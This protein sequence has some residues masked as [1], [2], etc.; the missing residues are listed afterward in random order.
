[1]NKLEESSHID[2]AFR[3]IGNCSEERIKLITTIRDLTIEILE[4]IVKSVPRNFSN[5]IIQTYEAKG[6]S[7]EWNLKSTDV[8]EFCFMARRQ[9]DPLI[10]RKKNAINLLEVC[11]RA[12]DDEVIISPEEA[13]KQIVY[14][15]AMLDA[16]AIDMGKELSRSNS[17]KAKKFRGK[18]TD[19]G[20]T[21]N[22]IIKDL[23]NN[24]NFEEYSAKELWLVFLGELNTLQVV[25]EEAHDSILIT[26]YLNGSKTS[27]TKTFKTFQ[28][29]LSQFKSR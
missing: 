26:Y 25:Y 19:D 20:K 8:N 13:V 1:M 14:A 5:E 24:P 28:S 29:N 21:L 11:T 17:I 16:D 4:P 23:V 2:S 22:E 10:Q 27:K 6:I 18:V 7:L 3:Q 12:L 15:Y 9:V